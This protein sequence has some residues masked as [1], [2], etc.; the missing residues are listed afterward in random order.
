MA[1]TKSTKGVKDV[2]HDPCEALA[3]LCGGNVGPPFDRELISQIVGDRNVL[4]L[5]EVA[6]AFGVAVGTPRKE[7]RP[8]GMP[9]EPKAWNLVDITIWR[10]ERAA[11]ESERLQ[12]ARSPGNER[13]KEFQ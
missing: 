6:K 3:K 9:G 1:R 11:K 8:A 5:A 10:L 4:T 2:V 12:V 7:W 13:I